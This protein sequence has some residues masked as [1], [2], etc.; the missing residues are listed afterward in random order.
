MTPSSAVPWPR[1]VTLRDGFPR[2]A[3]PQEAP[4]VAVGVG[5]GRGHVRPVLAQ[6]VQLAFGPALVGSGNESSK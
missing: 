1:Y 6:G 3:V 4:P 2:D 5:A